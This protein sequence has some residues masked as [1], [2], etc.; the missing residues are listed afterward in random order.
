MV[1]AEVLVDQQILRVNGAGL[2]RL[3]GR[4]PGVRLTGT[5]RAQG[6][7]VDAFYTPALPEGESAATLRL[8]WLPGTTR[9]QIFDPEGAPL[10]ASVSLKGPGTELTRTPDASGALQLVLNPGHWSVEVS[11][12]EHTPSRFG[13]DISSERAELNRVEVT[14]FPPEPAP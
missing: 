13:L 1:G 3:E 14:L 6:Y 11:A 8:A 7:Q 9:F 2:V 4:P 10:E 12:P 5:V